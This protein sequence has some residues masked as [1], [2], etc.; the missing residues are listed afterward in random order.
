MV[1]LKLLRLRRRTVLSFV[2][3]ATALA[4]FVFGSVGVAEARESVL[5]LGGNVVVEVDER[6]V[7]DVVAIGGTV[8]VLGDVLGDVVAVGG[9]V[10][11]GGTVTGDVVAVGGTVDLRATAQVDGD[12]TAVGGRVNRSPEAIVSGEISVISVGETFR[13]GFGGIG[14]E[15]FQWQLNFPLLLLYVAGLFAM[16]L[17]VL[18]VIPDNV[19]AIE[20][21]M[22]S[23]AG[24]GIVIGLLTMLLLL[25]LTLLLVLTIVGPPLLWIGYFAAKMVGYVALVSLVGRKVAERFATDVAPV[26]ELVVG[27]AVVAVLRYVPVFGAL[28]SLVVTLWSVG[29]VLDTKFGTN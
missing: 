2:L 1:S 21:H 28:F 15:F 8:E 16:A 13:F 11:L 5:R 24:R 23:N 7:G 22:E 19:H 26:W 25:P 10:S 6:T 12:V 3:V 27:V 4:V 20:E 17:V 9:T 18:A 29:A 14:T